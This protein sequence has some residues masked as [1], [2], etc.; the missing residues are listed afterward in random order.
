M[1]KAISLLILLILPLILSSCE[2][3]PILTPLETPPPRYPA[4]YNAEIT[5]GD[6]TCSAKIE[7]ES[8][9]T[10]LMTFTAPETISDLTVR[11][12][13]SVYTYETGGIQAPHPSA[14]LPADAIPN[15][16]FS[17]LREFLKSNYQTS[18]LTENTWRYGGI[19]NATPFYITQN[20]QTEN[21]ISLKIPQKELTVTFVQQ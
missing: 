10:F 17:A 21:L 2:K 18:E 9:E 15:L 3:I 6:F 20:S 5:V 13:N 19:S 12:E 16:I 7:W 4:S 11:L 8:T 1:K 14:N